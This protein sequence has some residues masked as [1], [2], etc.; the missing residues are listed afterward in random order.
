MRLAFV[1]VAVMMVVG[2]A[3]GE[4]EEEPVTVLSESQTGGYRAC[5]RWI[6][7]ARQARAGTCVTKPGPGGRGC[8]LEESDDKCEGG[9]SIVKGI[10]RRNRKEDGVVKKCGCA[11]CRK[12][13]ETY[14]KNKVKYQ[15]YNC[16]KSTVTDQNGKLTN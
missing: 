10:S 8:T 15:V 1:L 9:F 5:I 2:L 7:K 14:E 4:D 16:G 6:R 13:G 11:C 3:H 12:T